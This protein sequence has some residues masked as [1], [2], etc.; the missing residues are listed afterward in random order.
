MEFRP[1]HPLSAFPN[2]AQAE[3]DGA[4]A[5]RDNATEFNNCHPIL[6]ET[7]FGEDPNSM[8]KGIQIAIGATAIALML[9]WWG[10]RYRLRCLS[11]PFFHS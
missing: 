6:E 2:G 4:A 3:F 11:Q 1:Q 7:I 10:T 8:S 5:N 9:G